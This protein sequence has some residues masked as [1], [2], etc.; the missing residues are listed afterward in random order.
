M[1][2]QKMSRQEIE[3]EKILIEVFRITKLTNQKAMIKVE[4]EDLV[5]LA[6]NIA[7]QYL[8]DD[9]EGGLKILR[10][11]IDQYFLRSQSTTKSEIGDYLRICHD[12]KLR[13][14]EEEK[15]KKLLMQ[16]PKPSK[17]QENIAKLKE[18]MKEVIKPL[19]YDKD[20]K[21]ER[22][23]YA[24]GP[25][26]YEKCASVGHIARVETIKN[27]ELMALYEKAWLHGGLTYEEKARVKKLTQKP[28]KKKSDTITVGQE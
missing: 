4:N 23:L 22:D 14:Q 12:I 19:P 15:S 17:T 8:M 2:E 5:Y 13:Q 24:L 10:Q 21:K 1:F 11:G 27:K 25:E 28:S 18:M 26:L 20:I 9:L 7:D 6:K 16:K 3:A